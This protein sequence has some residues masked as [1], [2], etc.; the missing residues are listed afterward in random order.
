[1][2]NAI[3]IS[4]GT[5]IRA[6]RLLLGLSQS[7]LADRL[8]VTFQQIQKY[9]RGANRVGSSRLYKVAQALNVSIAYFFSELEPTDDTIIP[10]NSK[11]HMAHAQEEV[12]NSRET[13]ELVRAYYRIAS[14]SVRKKVLDLIKSLSVVPD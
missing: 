10:I 14:P 4:V 7:D 9:E 3:D 13:I 11:Q 12:L 2:P 6:R 5:K 1:M 8:G